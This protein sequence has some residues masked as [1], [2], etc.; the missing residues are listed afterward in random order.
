MFDYQ[1]ELASFLNIETEATCVVSEEENQMLRALDKSGQPLPPGYRKSTENS[2]MFMKA[3]EIPAT[4]ELE[5]KLKLQN[6]KNLRT[7]KNCLIFFTALAALQLAFGFILA[8]TS[9]SN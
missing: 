6:S 9:L 3:A 2:T 7:I 1:N 8:L 4:A 5:Q